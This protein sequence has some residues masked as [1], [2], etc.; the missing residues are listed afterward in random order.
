ML[1]KYLVALSKAQD[2]SKAK[3]GDKPITSSAACRKRL[4]VLYLLNDLL[5]HAKYH[6]P[7]S[8]QLTTLHDSIQPYL[9]EL[10]QLA[11]LGNRAKTCARIESLMQ[12]WED[13]GYF[14]EEFLCKLRESQTSGATSVPDEPSSNRAT[15]TGHLA[16]TKEQPYTIPASHG[17]PSTPY[18]D[19]PAGNMMPHIMPNRSV[20]IRPDDVRA[21]HFV[22]G[23]ADEALVIAVKEF[24]T[25]AEKIDAAPDVDD[26]GGIVEDIDDLGQSLLRDETGDLIPGR[27]YYGWSRDFCDKMKSRCGQK[28]ARAVAEGSYSSSRSR[29]RG[30]R[31]RR[32]YSISPSSTSG[33]YSRSRS[34]NRSSRNN[35]KNGRQE[36]PSSDGGQYERRTRSRSRSYSPNATTEFDIQASASNRLTMSSQTPRPPAYH[37]P[38]GIPPPPPIFQPGM[39]FNSLPFPLLPL[40]PG[41]VPIPPPPPP[42]YTGPWPPPPP[43]LP[44]NT[45]SRILSDIQQHHAVPGLPRPAPYQGEQQHF[46]GPDHNR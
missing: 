42:N 14:S 8:S 21:L 23:P 6:S 15:S 13:E 1:A 10:I 22:A 16:Y 11:S 46:R 12:V 24:M 26:D 3:D 5:H 19:L 4:H 29:S 28:A 34:R 36:Y 17:D 9:I 45:G 43:P 38:G 25:A 7:H 37:I 35:F 44:P 27:T 32:R 2:K 20:P 39:E 33:S 30:R 41:I 18:H 40:A 31:E